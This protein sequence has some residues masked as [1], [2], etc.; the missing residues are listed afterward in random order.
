MYKFPDNEDPYICIFDGYNMYSQ[1]ID[2]KYIESHTWKKVYDISSSSFYKKYNC[3]NCRLS[4]FQ[5]NTNRY[6][7]YNYMWFMAKN[8]L[9]PIFTEQKLYCNEIIIQNILK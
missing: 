6:M 7:S 3:E 8:N 1:V 4:I 9:A 5:M 2:Q